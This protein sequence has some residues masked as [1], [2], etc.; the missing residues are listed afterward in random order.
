MIT[1]LLTGLV[2]GFLMCIPIGPIN[3]WV[4][5]TQIKKGPKSALAIAAGGSLMDFTYFFVILS[6]LSLFTFSDGLTQGLKI[7]G[8]LIILIMGIKELFFPTAEISAQ[9]DDQAKT[10]TLVTSFFVGVLLYTSNPGLIVTMTG[11]G[12]FIKSLQI[13]EFNRINIFTVAFGLSL[14]SFFWFVFLSAIVKRYQEAIRTKYMARL[15]KISGILMLG[16]GIYMGFKFF[17]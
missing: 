7:I 9:V 16:L 11:L 8:I 12:A 14:G 15:A 4:V 17:S 10:K 13:F 3:V 5:N 2:I 6:G 1:A